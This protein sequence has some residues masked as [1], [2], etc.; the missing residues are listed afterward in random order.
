MSGDTEDLEFV[1]VTT[2][3][4]SHAEAD[5]IA[6]HLVE[7]RRAV[8]AKVAT[9]PVTSRYWWQGRLH[10]RSEWLLQA[11]IRR[12]DFDEIADEIRK[13]HSY[14]VPQVIANPLIEIEPHYR[15]W[16]DNEIDH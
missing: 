12:R 4:P 10:E 5:R 9:A 2:S 14:E 7:C 6:C 15:A 1:L 8:S 3:C 16:L 11:K 13:R